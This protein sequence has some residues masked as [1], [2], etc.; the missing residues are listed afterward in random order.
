[1][2][3]TLKD[4]A[5]ETNLSVTTV[6]LVLN[7]KP[8]RISEATRKRILDAAKQLHYRPNQLAVGLV[9]QRTNTIGLIIPDI[10]NHFYCNLA[11]GLDEE[12]HEHQCNIILINTGF[13]S[14]RVV[15]ALHTLEAR[16]VDAIVLTAASVTQQ[17]I[18]EYEQLIQRSSIPIITVD[19][20]Y[21]SLQCSAVQLNNR[22]GA[23]LA[24]S[25]LLSFGHTKIACITGP[26]QS[27][28]TKERL[29]G[30]KKAYSDAGVTPPDNYIFSGNYQMMGAKYAASRILHETDATAIFCFNDVM[31]LG[32]YQTLRD[33]N[34]A[35]PDDMSI[36]GFDN[37]DFSDMLAVPLTTVNQP[38]YEIGRAAARQAL[39]EIDHP[40][41]KKTTI[42]F[43]PQLIVRNSAC[44]KRSS[45]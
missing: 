1:M 31:A 30:Y 32:A 2:A 17:N 18:T 43:E 14:E 40:D 9:K 38:A 11:L 28:V 27:S 44:P 8:C 36:V 16:S 3:T 37:I 22:E 26:L 35:V 10:S 23:Y 45:N 7:Q 12:M 33:N 24:T 29:E 4:I 34:I 41:A 19:H 5:K 42:T 21:P 13:S 20:S 25:H 6:S 15:N 39:F